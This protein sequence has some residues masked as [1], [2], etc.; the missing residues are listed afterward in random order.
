MSVAG[1]VG[2]TGSAVSW[3]KDRFTLSAEYKC[4]CV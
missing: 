1:G 3:I 4:T 2:V